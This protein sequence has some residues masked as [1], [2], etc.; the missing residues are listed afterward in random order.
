MKRRTLK[1]LALAALA[2]GVMFQAGCSNSSRPSEVLASTPLAMDKAGASVS[3]DFNV[4]QAHVATGRRLMVALNFPL[5]D[6]RKL[7]NTLLQN[8]TPVFIEVDYV[9]DGLST[10]VL[11]QDNEALLHPSE[12][13]TD[14]H[15]ARLNLYGT[16]AETAFVL[17][18]GFLPPKPGRYTVTIKTVRDE[19]L[20]AG[21]ATTVKVATFYNTG[22]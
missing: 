9:H 3:V 8:D 22:E 5:T 6:G 1:V 19:P 17:I 2:I 18:A 21:I 15:L 16:D 14:D 4:T 13:R 7:E 20:F 11:T 12:K 10:P